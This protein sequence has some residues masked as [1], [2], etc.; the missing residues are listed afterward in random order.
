MVLMP[1]IRTNVP[2]ITAAVNTFVRTQS[3]VTDAHAIMVTHFTTTAT[4]AKKVRFIR[5][6]GTRI[7]KGKFIAVRVPAFLNPVC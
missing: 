2:K 7:N 6:S 4:T 3:A 1:Q 5:I